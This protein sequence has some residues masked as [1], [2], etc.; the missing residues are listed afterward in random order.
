M[1]QQA[2]TNLLG[3]NEKLKSLNKIKE[4]LNQEIEGIKKK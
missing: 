3:T 2:L 4:S 1:F